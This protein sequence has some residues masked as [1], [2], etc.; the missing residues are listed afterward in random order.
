MEEKFRSSNGI[1]LTNVLDCKDDIKDI[2]RI[3]MFSSQD[4]KSQ[5]QIITF[6]TIQSFITIWGKNI[7]INLR[8]YFWRWSFEWKYK[9]IHD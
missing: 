9:F 1:D 3:S 2:P 6:K 8:Q 4:K 5:S 7:I